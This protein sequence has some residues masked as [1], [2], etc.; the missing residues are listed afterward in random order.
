MRCRRA[1]FWFLAIRQ[2][3]ELISMPNVNR[4]LFVRVVSSAALL[5][6]IV[7]LWGLMA[8]PTAGQAADPSAAATRGELLYLPI[9][10]SIF[11]ENGQRTLEMAATL[12]IHN[13]NPDRQITIQRADYFDTS[14]RLLKRYV[15]KTLVLGPLQTTNIVIEKSDKSGGTGANFLVEWQAA[16]DASSPLVEAVMVNA[17]SNLGIAFTTQAKVV[18]QLAGK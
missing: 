11:Y 3:E 18:R 8:G 13:V 2:D 17:A 14:G 5:V 15:D 10:S 6:G 16:G 1:L 12:S 4:A 7:S 9:Y